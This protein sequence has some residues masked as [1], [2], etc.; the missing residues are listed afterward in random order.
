MSFSSPL[1]RTTLIRL[2]EES[3]VLGLCLHHIIIDGG[4]IGIFLEELGVLY[5]AFI[6]GKASPLP[7]LPIQYADFVHW[8]Q[9]SLTPEALET[10][11]SYW[12][13]WLAEEPP[14]LELPT[15]RP[16]PAVETFQSGSEWSHFSPDLIQEL[17]SLSQQAGSTLFTT[18]LAAFA[19]LL[20][21]YNGAK[22]IV[23]G[24][25]FGAR[26]HHQLEALIG[27]FTNG[28]FPRRIDIRGNPGF[29]ELLERV[30]QVNLSALANCDVP[31]EHL[32]KSLQPKR[33]L[34]QNPLCRVLLNLL[35]GRPEEELKL[36]GLTITPLQPEGLIRRDLILNI[37]Q[38]ETPA[39]TALHGWWR[40]KRDLFEA[41]TIAGMAENFQTLLEAIVA[42]PEQSV[43]EIPLN[44]K[45]K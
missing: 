11:H 2:G 29:S 3:H 44:I 42:N 39:G 12:E 19:T 23:V 15:E 41:D 24:V 5:S 28:T 40:Y 33:D 26:S 34:S 45:R 13:Q 10:R 25:P 21:R 9:Q 32:L 7:D 20:Y 31:L 43:N 14:P 27:V 17:K 38:K 22:E 37:Q 35:P 1:L 30:G 4:S 8:Q 16:L 18:I 36:S 6:S